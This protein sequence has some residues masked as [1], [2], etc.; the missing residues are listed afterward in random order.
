MK[1]DNGDMKV[2]YDEEDVELGSDAEKKDK[3]DDSFKVGMKIDINQEDA[4]KGEK[5]KFNCL[6]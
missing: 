3:K 2:Y 1:Y 5:N 4:V 6:N